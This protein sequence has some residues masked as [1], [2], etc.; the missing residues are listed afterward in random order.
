MRW[1]PLLCLVACGG[2]PSVLTDAPVGPPGSGT[3]DF[4][5]EVRVD[6]FPATCADVGASNVEIATDGPGGPSVRQFPCTTEGNGSS[7]ALSPGNH[8]V[9]LSL[10]NSVDSSVLTLPAQ[11]TTVNAGTN[12][13]GLFVFDFGNVCDASSCNGGCCSASGC[14]AQSDSQCGLGGVPCDDCAAVGLFCD[15]INGFCTSP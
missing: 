15:T 7:Q 9:V 4:S 8:I 5:W 2:G 13:L 11:T 10:V 14:V 6:G 1:L 12:Q 3:L